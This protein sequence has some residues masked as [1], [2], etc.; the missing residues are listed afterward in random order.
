MNLLL[1]FRHKVIH[2][3]TF[4][5]LLMIVGVQAAA[6]ATD[7][8]DQSQTQKS[9]LSATVLVLD[10]ELNDLTM[11]PDTVREEKRVKTLRPL[12]TEMLQDTYDYTIAELSATE[13]SAEEHGKGYVFDRP[14]VAARM[15]RKAAADW[16]VSGRLHKASFLFVYLKSQ[17]IDA[18]T[19]EIRA[20]YVV[21]IKGWEPRLTKKGVESL[22]VKINQ[23]LQTVLSQEE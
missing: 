12:L 1:N 18:A 10:F 19:G 23:D 16:V 20:D 9:S 14:P 3:I 21:E 11:H 4:L 13:R 6:A 5:S 15:A 8:V 7:S 17:L 2:P 22:A